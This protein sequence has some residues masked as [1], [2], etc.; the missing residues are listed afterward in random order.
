MHQMNYFKGKKKI[1]GEVISIDN[2]RYEVIGIIK[3]ETFS[4]MFNFNNWQ[5]RN[6][7]ESIFIPLGTGS[8]LYQTDNSIQSIYFQAHNSAGVRTLKNTIRQQLLVQHQM[9]H[10]FSF[11]NTGEE[12]LKIEKNIKDVLKKWN[13]ALS[14]IAGI[15]LI[16]GGIGLFSTLLISISERMTEIGVRKSIGATELHIFTNF[17][18]E[19]VVLS[20]IGA[21]IGISISLGI[22]KI[23][24]M[25]LGVNFPI[26]IQGVAIGLSFAFGIGIL[27]GIYPA[28]KAAK[29]DPIRAIFYF[30]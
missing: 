28:I 2:S 16:V 7:L 5:R 20:L 25:Q 10:D 26:P 23:A 24:G 15:S 22:V 1:L 6:D 4:G 13:M 9:S 18:V 19:A 8:R 27:S 11:Q 3:D 29:I 12:I 30:E 17:I 14:V 21:C